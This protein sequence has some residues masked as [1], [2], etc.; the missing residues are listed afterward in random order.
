MPITISDIVSIEL[1]KDEIMSAIA[2]AKSQLFIDNLRNRH[3]NVSFDSKLRGYIGEL[4]MKRWLEERNITLITENYIEEGGNID[5]DL[6]FRKNETILD[7]ELKTSLIPDR[8][9]KFENVLLNRDIK[10]IRRGNQ[11]IEDLKSDIH[12]QVYFRQL[13]K[14]K[15]EWLKQQKI[16]LSNNDLD[17][18]YKSFGASRY[19]ND[20]Y[21]FAWID[22]PT[23]IKQINAKRVNDRYW[24]FGMRQFWSCNLRSDAKKPIELVEYLNSYV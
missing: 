20:T 23:L 2:K 4:A 10:L 14:A 3:P 13:T 19:E 18:L 22:K 7:I 24:T 21:L 9:E 6:I 1:Q 16:D 15:D 8:D 11:T 17:Y 12:I 5:V